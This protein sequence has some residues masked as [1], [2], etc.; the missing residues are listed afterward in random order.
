MAPFPYFKDHSQAVESDSASEEHN[1]E[2]WSAF[3]HEDA[4]KSEQC[5]VSPQPESAVCEP[6]QAHAQAEASLSSPKLSGALKRGTK[7][8]REAPDESANESAK[9]MRNIGKSLEKLASGEA[10]GDVIST[11]CRYFEQRMR[12]L[13]AHVLPHFL[14]EVEN[15]LFKYSVDQSVP[16]QNSPGQFANIG[17]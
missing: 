11:Y 16:L 14:H 13:P 15:C 4:V 6:T 17:C 2:T 8:S 10:R 3:P 5:P 12:T 1:S 9:L 7:R